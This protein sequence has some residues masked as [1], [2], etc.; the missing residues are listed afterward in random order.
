[1][2][3]KWLENMSDFEMNLANIFCF[4]KSRSLSSTALTNFHREINP[5]K[6]SNSDGYHEEYEKNLLQDTRKYMYLSFTLY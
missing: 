4:L 5:L 1:M 6:F 3:L 2:K